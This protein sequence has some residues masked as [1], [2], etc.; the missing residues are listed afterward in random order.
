MQIYNVN[1]KNG[2]RIKCGMTDVGLILFDDRF[3]HSVRLRRTSVEM[4]RGGGIAGN[5][6]FLP[7]TL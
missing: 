2:F 6:A 3:L 1:N 7:E 5:V 4:T